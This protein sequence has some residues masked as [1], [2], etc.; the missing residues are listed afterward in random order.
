MLAEIYQ[1]RCCLRK[2]E[3]SGRCLLLSA[4]LLP[5]IFAPRN[6]S[7]FETTPSLLLTWLNACKITCNVCQQLDFVFAH[8]ERCCTRLRCEQCLL[9]PEGGSGERHCPQNVSSARGSVAI[10]WKACQSTEGLL[11]NAAVASN[12]RCCRQKLL[13]KVVAKSEFR[14]WLQR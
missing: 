1:Q 4:V 2:Y 11:A 10:R 6:H 3:A 7:Q 12:R 5:Q 13:G 8:N 14:R 9:R